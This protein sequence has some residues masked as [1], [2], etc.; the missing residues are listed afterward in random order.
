MDY[1]LWQRFI[2]FFLFS[3]FFLHSRDRLVVAAAAVLIHMKF[4][5]RRSRRMWHCQNNCKN[6]T[7]K[8]RKT[9]AKI[10][11]FLWKKKK[12]KLLHLPTLPANQQRQ[13]TLSRCLS[14]KKHLTSNRSW[15]PLGSQLDLSRFLNSVKK[16]KNQK[17][18]N[19]QKIPTW[20]LKW[21]FTYSA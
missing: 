21:H 4:N 10:W 3:F 9:W 12:K 18:K 7:L 8:L 1:T 16:K 11:K 6:Q 14:E 17:N 20:H 19:T 5:Y 15:D 2:L 13:F